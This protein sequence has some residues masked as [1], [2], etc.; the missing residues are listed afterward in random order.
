MRYT[1]ITDFLRAK[2][3]SVVPNFDDLDDW[4]VITVAIQ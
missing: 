3:L 4:E 2:Q 1:S